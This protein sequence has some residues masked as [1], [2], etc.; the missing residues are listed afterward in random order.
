MYSM[1]LL[2]RL[3][4]SGSVRASSLIWSAAVLLNEKGKRQRQREE[5]EKWKWKGTKGGF[6]GI[7]R[8]ARRKGTKKRDW[9]ERKRET[10]KKAEWYKEEGSKSMQNKLCFT[11]NCGSFSCCYTANP[12]TSLWSSSRCTGRFSYHC[13]F[14]T[15]IGWTP[16]NTSRYMCISD[17]QH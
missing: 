7:Q 9:T 13:C 2:Y 14:C 11:I 6:C 16:S 15:T 1:S 4:V 17:N 3:P 12:V 8:P 5:E 10:E